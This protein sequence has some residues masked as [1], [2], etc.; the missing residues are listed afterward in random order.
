MAGDRRD[1]DAIVGEIAA[2]LGI[3]RSYVDAFGKRVETPLQ[4]RQAL[5]AALGLPTSTEEE[6]E[7]SLMEALRLKR[8]LV[9]GLIPVDAER[10]WPLPVRQIDPAASVV[11]RLTLESG[12][13][14]E[15]RAEPGANGVI[16]MPALPPGY[17][18]LTVR[19]ANDTA[20]ATIIAAPPRCWLPP[21][22]EAGRRLW[23]ATAPVYSLRSA[24]DLGIGDYTHLAEAAEG[25]AAHG[26]S[27][28]GFTPVHAL[29]S[30]DR[31][32]ISP[33]SPS[34]RLFLET[35]FIDPSAADGFEGG[36]AARLLTAALR[37]EAPADSNGTPLIDYAAAW[38]RKRPILEA[39]W[40]DFRGQS[41]AEFEAFRLEGGPLLEAHATF[42]ALAEH[43]RE[44]GRYWLGEWEPPYRVAGSPEVAAFRAEHGERVGFHAFLQ[45][46]AD[47]Q[48][49]AAAGRARAAGMAVGLY[50]DLA[51]GA[52]GAGSEIWSEPGRFCPDLSIG[53]PPDPLALQGQLW[54]LAPFNPLVLE[55]EGLAP[56]RALIRANMRHAGAIRI[57]H[58][59][60]LRRLFLVPAGE[61]AANGAYVDYPFEAMLAVL[62]LESH[63]CQTLV[64]AEDLGTAPAGFSQTI[65][66]AGVLSYRVLYF[67]RDEG[68][69]FKNPS[70]YPR[71]AVAVITTHDL[72]TFA[73]WWKA[74]D[75]DWRARLGVY[76]A[77][78]AGREYA[79]RG[80]DR[81][82]LL[83]LMAEER[84][85]RPGEAADQPPLVEAVR[86]LARTPSL[87]AA[88]QL[89]D[90]AG[91][92][93]QPNIPGFADDDHP[94]WRRRL[95]LPIEALMAP[96]GP[97]ERIGRAMAMEG[98]H[99]RISA[100]P[101]EPVR[102]SA[103]DLG[104][105]TQTG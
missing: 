88:V 70:E 68:G 63:R 52:D 67:E 96:A 33:Y 56:F 55:R 92:I 13:T 30:S 105:M 42:E 94:N 16:P 22:L 36:E 102:P 66:E 101:I 93:E 73:G 46:L 89:E 21:E 29:F 51:V 39:L 49:A 6:A 34:S 80:F 40:R 61:K 69:R 20:E 10:S 83:A 9:P 28:F 58:A 31:T 27:F 18:R 75:V 78:T 37:D 74:R 48:L 85:R 47:R 60:Q 41:S 59:F 84:L 24:R 99:G 17:H 87:L 86:L 25:A 5:L 100:A 76:D 8:G 19:A 38:D 1:R 72:P 82:Q 57:D 54:G 90:A 81:G 14:Q 15:D 71:D 23:G 12:E 64:I 91:E 35:N 53:A 98:R 97:V 26:A 79:V 103:V 45:W 7:T 3:E 32:K 44:I 104:P 2:L 11:W 77:E 4:S 50:R 43:F 65:N 62:R 95:S